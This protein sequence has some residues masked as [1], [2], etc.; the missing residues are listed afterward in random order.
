MA[1]DRKATNELL[2]ALQAELQALRAGDA[3]AA[4][5]ERSPAADAALEAKLGEFGRAMA[6]LA[7]RLAAVDQLAAGDNWQAREAQHVALEASV[8]D[9]LRK[10]EEDSKAR[11]HELQEIHE[12]MA[13]LG[14]GQQLL[15][16]NL[17]SWRA[18]NGGDTAIVSNR[19]ERLEH[20]VLDVMDRLGG[21][22]QAARPEPHEEEP[23]RGVGFKRWLYGTGNVLAGGWREEL[24]SIRR[25]LARSRGGEK[26]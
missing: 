17:A 15:A 3:R 2:R 13:Q 1:A 16:D 26:S 25:T 22:P 24:A 21:A 8:R 11:E 18:E 23:R 20:N 9:Q 6:T 4:G 12:A 10:A 7:G 19:L 5:G 14:T